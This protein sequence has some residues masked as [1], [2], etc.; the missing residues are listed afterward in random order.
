VA[1]ARTRSH[2]VHPWSHA[3]GDPGDYSSTS[4]VSAPHFIHDL[5]RRFVR[6]KFVDEAFAEITNAIAE[7]HCIL[8]IMDPVFNTT[9]TMAQDNR[10]NV[11]VDKDFVITS[12]TI[13]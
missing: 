4:R 11:R 8:N 6:E 1:A 9:N 10:V 3:A 2:A 7:H 12:I 13:G 5:N